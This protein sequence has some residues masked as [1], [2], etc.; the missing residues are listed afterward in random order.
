MPTNNRVRARK[1][2][3]A[4]A[5]RE[6]YDFRQLNTVYHYER[7]TADCLAQSILLYFL[8]FLSFNLSV[9]F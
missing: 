8:L 3:A 1:R 5:N 9:L 2:G 7:F 4:W 6:A